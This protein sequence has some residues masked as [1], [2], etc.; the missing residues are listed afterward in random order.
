VLSQMAWDGFQPSTK[1]EKT[2]ALPAIYDE[3]SK[4]K[5]AQDRFRAATGRLAAAK[6]EG[7]FKSAAG[8]VNKACGACH[9]S[10]R[11]K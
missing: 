6:D 9:Q 3:P 8:E 5:E 7:A 1:D 11:A 2:R 4:F 10:F